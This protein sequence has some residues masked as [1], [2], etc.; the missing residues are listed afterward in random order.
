MKIRYL[1]LKNFRQ[2]YGEHTVDFATNKQ[3]NV[4]VIQGINGAGKTSLFIALNWCLYGE[5]FFKEDIGE[6]VSKRARADVENG[7]GRDTVIE[8][9]IELAFESGTTTNVGNSLTS[10]EIGFTY[11]GN[12]YCVKREYQWHGNEATVFSVKEND[13]KPYVDS[14]AS[15]LI[16]QLIPENVSVHFFFDGEKIDNF[17]KPGEE[18]IQDAVRNVLK[19]EVFDR[20]IRHLKDVARKYQSELKQYASD[21]SKALFDEKE[22]TEKDYDDHDAEI[23]QKRGEIEKAEKQLKDIDKRLEANEISRALADERKKVEE[24]LEQIKQEK[25][26]FQNE[27]IRNLLNQGAIPLA[28]SALDKALEILKTSERPGGIP[29]PILDELI[30]RMRCLCGREIEDGSPE[31][32]NIQSLLAQAVS[33]KLEFAIGETESSLK[34]LIRDSVESIPKSLK[35]ALNKERE[36]SHEIETN[37]ARLGEIKRKLIDFDEDEVGRLEK[38][39][40]KYEQDIRELK[41]HVLRIEG[42][43]QGLK[44]E[45]AKLKGKIEKEKVH[46][47]KEKQLKRYWQLATETASAMETLYQYFLDD[48]REEIETEVRKI[49]KQLVWKE[50]QFQDVRLSEKYELQVIDRFGKQARPE[51][52]A[53][54]RQV[55]SLAFIAAMAKIAV[56]KMLPE[57]KSEPFPM[58]MDTPFGRLST[59]HRENITEAIPDIAEQL[60]LFVTDE[61]LHGQA[62]KNLEPRIGAEYEL[63]FDDETGSSTIKKIS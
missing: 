38:A 62:R 2:Y 54:E 43:M 57:M 36:M 40:G 7:A 58:V 31:H 16:Q 3:R 28:K 55:L 33:P 13:L 51:M 12:E 63:Q 25:S 20:S 39:R 61:E 4:T 45:I 1:K 26:K 50:S 37:E 48:K 21:S 60:V 41:D 14:A 59:Q 23:K 15:E 5:D 11:Q 35:L 10:V 52:S 8:T 44:D 22:K 18:Q 6:F 53:G 56:E 34:R 47:Q 24:K 46:G 29:K 30:E 49:F 32:Q 17:A 42:R 9:V 27:E 19:H